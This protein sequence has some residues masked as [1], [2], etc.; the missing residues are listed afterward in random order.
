M[1]NPLPQ[2]ERETA[3]KTKKLLQKKRKKNDDEGDLKTIEK[4]DWKLHI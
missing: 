3:N 2:K 1:T 4:L